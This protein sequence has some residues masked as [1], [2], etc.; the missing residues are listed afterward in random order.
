MLT[1]VPLGIEA[2]LD[3]DRQTPL[4][5]ASLAPIATAKKCQRAVVAASFAVCSRI[6]AGRSAGI[7]GI[8]RLLNV[9]DYP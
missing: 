4:P 2:E 8:C 1:T 5:C 7:A 6:R 3:L 9:H